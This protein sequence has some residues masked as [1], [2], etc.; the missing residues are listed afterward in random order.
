MDVHCCLLSDVVT[1]TVQW[2]L[3]LWEV[4]GQ[5]KIKADDIY[6]I[7]GEGEVDV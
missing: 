7:R 3:S 2:Y 6:V 5:S 1:C 4:K